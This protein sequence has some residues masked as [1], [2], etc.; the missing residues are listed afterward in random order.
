ME[1]IE[2][3]EKVKF[4]KKSKIARLHRMK[5][6][7]PPLIVYAIATLFMNGFEGLLRVE[8][9]IGIVMIYC[10]VASMHI[11]N[12]M[13]DWKVDRKVR[14]KVTKLDY[15]YEEVSPL[16]VKT[17][18]ATV[19]ILMLAT[20]LLLGSMWLTVLVLFGYLLGILYSRPP[21]RTKGV[22]FI[23]IFSNYYGYAI[24]MTLAAYLIIGGTLL[25]AL[26][27]I[28]VALPP[29]LASTIIAEMIDYSVD[30]RAGDRTTAIFL[31]MKKS[32][33]IIFVL[34][35]ITAVVYMPFATY[36]LLHY[37]NPLPL[38][39]IPTIWVALRDS[40]KLRKKPTENLANRIAFNVIAYATFTGVLYL[41]LRIPLYFI[42]GA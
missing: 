11:Y 27:M 4:G 26:I 29:A 10:L 24:L 28:C 34:M 12:Q 14:F 37:M 22:P 7:L 21:F 40:W 16:Y 13:H 8:F 41:I 38:L 30:K 9:Y 39:F 2:F 15:V 1:P 3:F 31:G 42:L 32:A 25:R 18:L 6:I 33:N 35:V 20:L 17:N 5:G 23:G 36:I 19:T